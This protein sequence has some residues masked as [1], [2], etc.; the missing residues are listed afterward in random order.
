MFD[1]IYA[2]YENFLSL[3]L[4]FYKYYTIFCDKNQILTEPQIAAKWSIFDLVE[5]W[6]KNFSGEAQKASRPKTK[7]IVSRTYLVYNFL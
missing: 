5:T 3:S 7:R 1:K 6:S 2:I 4:T